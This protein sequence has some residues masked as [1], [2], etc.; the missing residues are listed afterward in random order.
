MQPYIFQTDSD[1]LKRKALVVLKLK[2]KFPKR[3]PKKRR[4]IPIG[5]TGEEEEEG[6]KEGHEKRIASGS[7]TADV[8]NRRPVA[9]TRKN[10]SLKITKSFSSILE[11]S[12]K[13]NM[14]RRKREVLFFY[15]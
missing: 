3:G 10:V 13:K 7:M 8:S 14:K 5:E 9:V 12:M 4:K 11:K 2:K 6:R 1:R 15:F